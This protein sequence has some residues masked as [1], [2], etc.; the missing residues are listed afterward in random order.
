MSEVRKFKWSPIEGS[1]VAALVPGGFI[2]Q[3]CRTK[4]MVFIP[5]ESI[6][7]ESWIK[8]QFEAYLEQKKKEKER[9]G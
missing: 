8:A 9:Y 7:A 6:Y 3:D 4:C 5:S 1:T 2:I